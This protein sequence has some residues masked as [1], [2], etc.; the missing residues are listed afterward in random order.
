MPLCSEKKRQRK[1]DGGAGMT[2]RTERT[3]AKRR[4]KDLKVVMLSSHTNRI[5]EDRR[6]DWRPEEGRR[7]RTTE[8]IIASSY[9]CTVINSL[10]VRNLLPQLGPGLMTNHLYPG[11]RPRL[12][13]IKEFIRADQ[14]ASWASI[15]L[16]L[17]LSLLGTRDNLRWAHFVTSYPP[18]LCPPKFFHHIALWYLVIIQYC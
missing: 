14:G 5:E 6:K 17:V 1:K 2:D 18:L 11:L 3:L 8:T 12:F 7:R 16:E 10:L 13:M 15:R 9:H 4:K